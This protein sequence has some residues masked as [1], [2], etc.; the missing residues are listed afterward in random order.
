MTALDTAQKLFEEEKFAE[1]RTIAQ[2]ALDDGAGSDERALKM[3]V[4]KC[5]T[6]VPPVDENKSAAPTAPAAAAAAAAP[7]PAE[8]PA[9]TV[10]KPQTTV[11]NEWFQTAET[12]T[13]TFYAK[14][15]TREQVVTNATDRS[16]DISITL[17]GDSNEWQAAYDPLFAAV[18]GDAVVVN[19]KQPKVEVV[20]QKAVPGLHWASLELKGDALAAYQTNATV[21]AVP[22]EALPKTQKQ[23]SY[24]NSK[25]RDWSSY[26]PD[27]EDEKLEGDAALNKLFRDIYK[28]AS[29][30]NRRAMVK[31]FTESNGTVLS[32]NWSDVG[33]RKV[34]GEA[35]KGM[36]AKKWEQ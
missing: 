32:T 10:P 21:A 27:E 3:I 1:A 22:V 7:A 33:S 18:K 29:E 4:R 12:V 15:R 31:S 23:L 13:L 28:D 20:L 17:D 5:N 11:R 19:V 2:A 30:E 26:K 9:P 35:P 36:E 34:E 6:H 14:N 24:P 8:V 25:G 16:F